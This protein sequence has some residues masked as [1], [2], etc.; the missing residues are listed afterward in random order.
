MGWGHLIISRYINGNHL[1]ILLEMFISKK[2]AGKQARFPFSHQLQEK[3]SSGGH[4]S[5]SS[6]RSRQIGTAWEQNHQSFSQT[7]L[8][9]AFSFPS[10]GQMVLF[11]STHATN[12][13]AK[14]APSVW[15]TFLT[16]RLSS[17]KEVRG[18]E[19]TKMGVLPLNLTSESFIITSDRVFA[20]SKPQGTFFF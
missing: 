13:T 6:R 2:H 4:F 17:A 16:F 14:T 7:A 20:T 9:P 15:P 8:S 19:T 1:Q 18:S 3:A 11:E 5:H 12:P 10:R